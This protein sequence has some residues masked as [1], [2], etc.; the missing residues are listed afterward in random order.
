MWVSHEARVVCMYINIP[1][2]CWSVKLPITG[3][4]DHSFNRIFCTAAIPGLTQEQNGKYR[5]DINLPKYS[6][7]EV[8]P[9]NFKMLPRRYA[10]MWRNGTFKSCSVGL[11]TRRRL[12]AVEEFPPSFFYGWEC[13]LEM[14]V[15]DLA[16]IF[17]Y[18]DKY[19]RHSHSRL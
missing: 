19:L 12:F 11:I 1:T 4:N 18:K 7:V 6:G 15:E 3:R 14:A 17:L 10:N 9:G 2:N 13:L 8:L 5:A 16:L